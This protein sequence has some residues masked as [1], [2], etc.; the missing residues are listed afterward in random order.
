MYL[1]Y[2]HYGAKETKH[3]SDGLGSDFNADRRLSS[4]HF[5]RMQCNNRPERFLSA[6]NVVG[7]IRRADVLDCTLAR[8]RDAVHPASLQHTSSFML[9]KLL[10]TPPAQDGGEERAL[11]G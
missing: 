9:S 3:S 4:A 5:K 10:T 8:K 6:A 2:L 11:N 7:K 1:R